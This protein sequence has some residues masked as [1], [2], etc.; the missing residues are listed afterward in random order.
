M[1]SHRTLSR[2]N[3]CIGDDDDDVNHS[4]GRAKVICNISLLGWIIIIFGLIWWVLVCVCVFLLG[5]SLGFFPTRIFCFFFFLCFH[6]WWLC[7]DETIFCSLQSRRLNM[8]STAFDDDPPTAQHIAQQ[9]TRNTNTNVINFCSFR[10]GVWFLLKKY[11]KKKHWQ[12]I[13]NLR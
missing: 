9:F 1:D 4:D 10:T 6:I 2:S 5:S 3:V 7:K 12:L 13:E 11:Q 8:P